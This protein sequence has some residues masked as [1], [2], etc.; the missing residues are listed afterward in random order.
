MRE[1][2]NEIERAVA[3]VTEGSLIE[4]SNLSAKIRTTPASGIQGV[5]RRHSLKE[6]VETL[7][8]SVLVERLREHQGNKTRVA[9]ELGLSRNGLMKKMRRYG[10]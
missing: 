10:L 5:T 6:M 3:M 8:K 7:E 4:L 2:E 9:E 1:L